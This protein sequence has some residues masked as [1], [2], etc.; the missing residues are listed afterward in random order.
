MDI[1][2]KIDMYLKKLYAAREF[3]MFANELYRNDKDFHYMSN[4][5]NII[6]KTMIDNGLITI[7]KD[8]R[9]LT[10]FGMEISQQGGWKSHLQ[11]IR[12]KEEQA[13]ERTRKEDLKLKYDLK[14]SRFSAKTIIWFFIMSCVSLLISIYTLFKEQLDRLVE[15]AFSFFK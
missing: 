14:V 6:D 2:V 1:E 12:E 13:V 11:R 8:V 3:T 9:M 10:A 5:S 7:V 4:V 15:N